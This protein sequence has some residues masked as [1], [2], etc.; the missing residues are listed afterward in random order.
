MKT[1]RVMGT[2]SKLYFMDVAAKNKLE[3]YDI[4]NE[5]NT[6]DWFDVELDETI[7]IIEVIENDE[8]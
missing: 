6:N 2:M 1:F 4:A 3:A 8:E 5:R 7:E